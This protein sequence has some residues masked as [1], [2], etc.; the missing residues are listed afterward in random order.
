M[1]RAQEA[2]DAPV[3]RSRKG[4]LFGKRDASSRCGAQ[5]EAESRDVPAARRRD[6]S[7][8]IRRIRDAD[9]IISCLK[10]SL[11]HM[12]FLPPFFLRLR[13][14]SAAVVLHGAAAWAAIPEVGALAPNFNLQTLSGDQVELKKLTAERP[15]ALIVLRGWPGYQCPLCSR[16]VHD[17]VAHAAEFENL[18]VQVVMIYPGPADDLK[19]HAKEFLED[20]KWPAAFLYLV[21]PDYVFT[22]TYDLRWDALKETAYPSTFVIGRDNRIRFA[23]VSKTHGDRVDAAGLLDALR[24]EK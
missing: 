9:G 21:D 19:T 8:E 2:M 11:I 5:F 7:A 13:I 17:L 23:H 10:G 24:K 20:K 3:G 1:R 6:R 18:G 14:L 15:V 22:K 16:Q 4:K 12:A